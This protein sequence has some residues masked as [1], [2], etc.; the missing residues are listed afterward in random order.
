MEV[1][2]YQAAMWCES[3]GFDIR[4]RLSLP[5]DDIRRDDSNT[6]PQGPYTDG[7]GE[8]DTPQHCDG[9]G[10]FLQ[11]PLTGDG[12]NYVREKLEAGEGNPEVLAE[13][14]DFYDYLTEESE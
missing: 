12:E 2:I 8:A 1:F 10:T 4:T 7:G 3:C 9:C 13:W 5:R 6:F 14:R 11:N